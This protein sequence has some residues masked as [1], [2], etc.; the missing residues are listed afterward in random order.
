M[1]RAA[2]VNV[3]ELM[4]TVQQ[5]KYEDRD[6][7]AQREISMKESNEGQQSIRQRD[8]RRSRWLLRSTV[9]REFLQNWEREGRAKWNSNQASLCRYERRLLNYELAVKATAEARQRISR[10]RHSNDE[11]D[12]IRWFEHN[13][14]RLGLDPGGGSAD[15]GGGASA[16]LPDKETPATFRSRLVRAVLDQNFVP[17]SNA[18]AMA[19]LRFRGVTGRRG[20]KEREDRRVKTD[21]DQRRATAET[22]AKRRAEKHLKEMLDK[23]RE[24][25][26]AAA[27]CWGKRRNF[28]QKAITDKR[29]FAEMAAA[30]ED[31]FETAFNARA[32]CTR[33]SY[34]EKRTEREANNEALCIRLQQTRNE[35]RRRAETMCS[36]IV[37][38]MSD[39]AVV[40]SELR[41]SRGGVPLP[42]T[43]WAHLK[44]RF[45]SPEPFFVDSTPPEPTPEPSDPVLD[46]KA[47]LESQN[48]DRC[49]GLWRLREEVPAELSG[50]P[51][52][53]AKALGVA[54]DLVEAS[55]SM[56]REAPTYGRSGRSGV[57]NATG[58]DVRLVL[59][60]RR[61]GLVDLAAEL[62][63]W[64]DL[65]VCSME[66]ALECAMEV[67]AEAAASDGK[68]GKNRKGS[69]SG[70]KSS[71][72][73]ENSRENAA[74]ADA[75]TAAEEAKEATAR[76][77]FHPDATEED[78]T[79]FKAAAIAYH[80]LRTHPKKASV[81]VPL[82]TTT[83]LLVKH[84]SCRAPN[85]RG[86]I[87]VGYPTTLLESKLLENAL[88][89]YTD[90]D[91]AA[92]LGT[93]GKASKN[94]AKTRKVSSAPQQQEEILHVLP[95]S[96][97]DAVLS[98]AEPCLSSP[99]E[100]TLPQ[101]SVAETRGGAEENALNEDFAAAAT[102]EEVNGNAVGQNEEDVER[103]KS[104]EERRAQITWLQRFESGHLS[105]DVPNEAN[106]ERLLETLFLLVN[107]AQNR[108]DEQEIWQQEAALSRRSS[109]VEDVQ[110]LEGG[111]SSELPGDTKSHSTNTMAVDRPSPLA[112]PLS[113]SVEI[114]RQERRGNMSQSTRIQLE[115]M[116]GDR[117][118]DLEGVRLAVSQAD[119]SAADAAA[120][121]CSPHQAALRK[122]EAES[123]ALSVIDWASTA[124]FS[125]SK[126]LRNPDD[127]WTT[128]CLRLEAQM[129]GWLARRRDALE[130][131]QSRRSRGDR[132]TRDSRGDQ[133]ITA[134]APPAEGDCVWEALEAFQLEAGNV[135]DDRHSSAETIVGQID[136]EADRKLR[137]WIGDVA[138]AATDLCVAER[139]AYLETV[140][141]LRVFDRLFGLE[142]DPND[143]TN[144]SPELIQEATY[145]A[146]DAL[147]EKV[148]TT[149]FRRRFAAAGSCLGGEVQRAVEQVYLRIGMAPPA[150]G[151]SQEP[152]T[153]PDA[154]CETRQ[155]NPLSRAIEKGVEEFSSSAGQSNDWAGSKRMPTE[156]EAESSVTIEECGE[157][158]ASEALNEAIWRCRQTYICR[159]RGVVMRLLRAVG[160]CEDKVSSM[161]LA[162]RRLKRRRVQLEHQGISAATATVRRAL[163]ECDHVIL[164]DMLENGIP[165]WVEDDET[166]AA[167][168]FVALPWGMNGLGLPRIDSLTDSLQ[169][170]FSGAEG[171][172]GG[173]T[174]V[175]VADLSRAVRA[176]L[177]SEITERN[178]EGMMSDIPRAW[179]S[180]SNGY[181]DTLCS[182]TAGGMDD[183]SWRRLIHCLLLGHVRSLPTL[184]D[185]SSMRNA[186][187]LK[188]STVSQTSVGIGSA[189]GAASAN[190]CSST[191]QMPTLR[192]AQRHFVGIPLWF[193]QQRG[194]ERH[195]GERADREALL[196]IRKVYSEAWGGDDGRVDGM[197]LLLTL[198]AVPNAGAGGGISLGEDGEGVWDTGIP[199]SAGLLRAFFMLA[200]T[201]SSG[202]PND[203]LVTN[204]NREIASAGTIDSRVAAPPS[205]AG[206]TQDVAT[207]A[208]GTKSLLH[209]DGV[210]PR[211]SLPHLRAILR[212]GSR[213]TL[214]DVSSV[215]EL[216]AKKERARRHQDEKQG[217]G[218]KQDTTAEVVVGPEAT[219]AENEPA[220]ARQITGTSAETG[221]T[222]GDCDVAPDTAATGDPGVGRGIAVQQKEPPLT[223]SF[224]VVS[225]CEVVRDWV[226]KGAY[227][228]P[229]FG[230]LSGRG[231]DTVNM[232][233]KTSHR[234]G[235]SIAESQW[236]AQMV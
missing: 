120:G 167:D 156:R 40:S 160:S 210:F 19:E 180:S 185:L 85:G 103:S 98:M 181:V 122:L 18:E 165:L 212:H 17:S 12:G 161:R 194:E 73:G 152:V 92:E 202:P 234:L 192:I 115:A 72:G 159:L 61:D 117:E 23:G 37:H 214:A 20:R 222:E 64:V 137:A 207:G 149:S 235:E 105:C 114:L 29:R 223:V 189:A 217:H 87:L 21:V 113:A 108:K 94:D 75:E 182:A 173:N 143:N 205:S 50:A 119:A 34:E 225:E 224:D 155:E 126:E 184:D 69:I 195:R 24:R 8:E 162:L 60:S 131:M 39:L 7:A 230:V 16:V 31:A 153:L 9:R 190:A 125:F 53:L 45:C 218:V 81:P 140:D 116:M 154:A 74:G 62:G 54:R 193:E 183:V 57:D 3:K 209:R 52:P 68:G 139:V 97:L 89:G 36:E 136:G 112:V 99:R 38:K 118:L 191:T 168:P 56:Q 204:S 79:A 186:L 80:A 66:T 203:P 169:R 59:L 123:P 133:S 96:G 109:E 33:Q 70:R 28:E 104:L 227:A 144:T 176:W 145:A 35:K 26:E 178:R 232:L 127:R 41:A 213:M 83:D 78:T 211:V 171:V 231:P 138:C 13:L 65:Y 86:W 67:G 197:D 32:D 226:R 135:V 164:E 111:G 221:A 147:A 174:V 44:R 63:R 71:V 121:A 82:A 47:V 95:R 124:E 101:E 77:C 166:F 132:A 130:A 219:D 14:D 84:L 2:A 25:R 5:Q 236:R 158:K 15:G 175:A 177:H 206:H 102:R 198:C 150:H 51:S 27:A 172:P 129:A 196:S 208:T 106:N 157:N 90:E 199:F 215:C 43:A 1:T 151:P 229:T 128:A 107:A 179:T 93:G 163:Q 142:Q 49:E 216:V 91:V 30:Q 170:S 22:D 58:P 11:A 55:G 100:G 141:T 88:S 48:L 10:N 148:T 201:S 76:R 4:L 233:A 200:E 187:C 6:K 42:P 46:A 228:L 146:A 134:S 110:T 220:V 188:A